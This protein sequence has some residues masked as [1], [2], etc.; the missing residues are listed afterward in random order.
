MHIGIACDIHSGTSLLSHFPKALRRSERDASFLGAMLLDFAEEETSA[1]T[2]ART[3]T[4]YTNRLS[5]LSIAVYSLSD[6]P[7]SSLKIVIL[8]VGCDCELPLAGCCIEVSFIPWVRPRV[9][10]Q[11]I[12]ETAPNQLEL[13]ADL[14]FV[15]RSQ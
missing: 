2:R 9:Y 14:L 15:T 1:V 3:N 8:Y 13:R 11:Q 5:S 4:Y 12:K 6:N 10:L 7:V